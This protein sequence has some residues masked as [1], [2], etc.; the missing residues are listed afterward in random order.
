M[1]QKQKK[2]KRSDAS[3]FKHVA[4]FMW[5]VNWMAAAPQTLGKQIVELRERSQ[6]PAD[7]SPSQWK[8]SSY[9]QNYFCAFPASHLSFITSAVLHPI[10]VRSRQMRSRHVNSRSAVQHYCSPSLRFS[11]GI[12][13][14]T[15]HLRFT[16]KNP[17]IFSW[18]LWTTEEN[19]PEKGQRKLPWSAWGSRLFTFLHHLATAYVFFNQQ[20]LSTW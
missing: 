13:A 18:L 3:N 7:A 10:T 5:T 20:S 14:F 4:L 19:L 6:L 1:G 8:Q 17:N 11:T 2:G 9:I 16:S 12:P 15:S